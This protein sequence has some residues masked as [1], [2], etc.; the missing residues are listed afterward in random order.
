[1]KAIVKYGVEDKNVEL[2]DVPEPRV[3]PGHVLLAMR[4]AGV[5]G[6]DVEFWRQ[7]INVPINV[8][9]VMGH[10]FC[11]VVAELG[12]GAEGFSVGDR[13]VSETPA[14]IC[15]IC[16]FCRSGEYNVCPNRLDFGYGVDGAFT[17]FVNVPVRCLHRIPDNVPFEHSAAT[18][19]IA[20]SY[21]AVVV[22]SSVYPGDLVVVLGPGPIGIFC[23]QMAKVQGASVIVTGLS[24]DAKRLAA[25]EQIGFE[26]VLDVERHD[27]AEAVSVRTAG[28]GASLV[29]DAAGAQ[30]AFAQAMEIVKRNGQITKVAWSPEPL[31]MSLDPI[32]AKAVRV[33]GSFSHTWRTWE[34]VLS[35]LATGSLDLSAMIT[36]QFPLTD[37]EHAFEAAEEREA[38]KAVLTP[39]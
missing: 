37:W 26:A 32:T 36:H 38:V 14:K 21:N 33:Q 6:S 7:K 17:R 8:P 9:V 30:T 39:V 13:V 31:N 19:P 25:A 28:V 24:A 27:L 20:V 23:A 3:S 1:M 5:C 2:R 35:L 16:E 15:G 34:R 18:E 12:E 11:G 4:A 29:V 22:Q 10:E